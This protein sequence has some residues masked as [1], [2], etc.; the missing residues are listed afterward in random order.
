MKECLMTDEHRIKL[1]DHYKWSFKFISHYDIWEISGSFGYFMFHGDFQHAVD[2]A[3]SAQ[4]KWS[5]G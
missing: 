1:I 4:I 2:E 3:M 5:I